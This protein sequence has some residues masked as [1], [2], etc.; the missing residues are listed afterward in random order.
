MLHFVVRRLFSI[1]LVSVL[2]VF[3]IYLGM[4]VTMN[5][6]ENWQGWLPEIDPDL[7]APDLPPLNQLVATAFQNAVTFM[8]NLLKGE[9][10]QVYNDAQFQGSKQP[11]LGLLWFWYKNSLGLILL[12]LSTAVFLGILTGSVAALTQSKQREYL[13]LTLTILGISAPSF[14][15][16]V[17]LQQTGIRITAAVGKSYI[18][19]GGYAWDFKHL[20]LPI[21]VMS[22]RP[23][24]FI[25][26]ATFIN[27]N[28]IMEQDFIRTAHAKGLYF[29]RVVVVHAF[30]NL[31]IP[32][33]ASIGVSFRFSLAVLPLVEYIF[34]WPG[35]GQKILEGVRA[36]VPIQVVSIA[37]IMALTV[38]LVGFL[39]DFLYRLIDPRVAMEDTA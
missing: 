7:L 38:Q 27:L 13:M 26:R 29:T 1:L 12:S 10:G 5:Y 24:A 15:L 8:K 11:L 3:L 34:A 22:A 37:L 30:R 6:T 25:T 19:M 39:L 32:I 2:L 18:S 23:V 16:A 28:Q 17:V 14:L 35:L 20:L 33:L 9:L 36:K 31:L 21:L 4:E